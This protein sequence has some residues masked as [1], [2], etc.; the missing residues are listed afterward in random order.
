MLKL[1]SLDQGWK[2]TKMTQKSSGTTSLISFHL[3]KTKGLIHLRDQTTKKQV[4]AF[5]TAEFINNYF[6]NIGP[7]LA[8]KFTTKWSFDGEPTR[9]SMPDMAVTTDQILKFIKQINIYKP[10]AIDLLSS[11]IIKDAFLAIPQIVTNL[12][13]LSITQNKFPTKWKSATIIPLFKGGDREDVNNMRPVSLL[14]LPGKILE[15]VVHSSISTYL[16]TNKILNVKQ[17]GF[18]AGHSTLDTIASFTDDIL[19]GMNAGE[20]TLATFIDL[21]KAFDTVNHI[22]LLSK[23]KELGIKG[24]PL[25]WIKDYIDNRNQKTYANGLTSTSLRISCGVPQGSVLGPLLFLIYINDVDVNT[26]YCKVCLYADDTVLYVLDKCPQI[27]HQKMQ[28]DIHALSRWCNKN[29]LTV[30]IKKTKCVLFASKYRTRKTRLLPISMNGTE[31]NYTD[32][33]KYL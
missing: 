5:Q 32:H 24:N 16:E 17:G 2:D 26:E 25:A 1:T 23:L 22:I 13:N 15:K 19:I 11:R 18:R 27:A 20:V 14:P 21:C 29:Q 4:E 33:Y 3:K 30:N 9:T 6:T 28:S 7:N 12:M 10:S 31:L 8:N